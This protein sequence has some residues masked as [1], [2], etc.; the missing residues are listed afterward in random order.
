M[1]AQSRHRSDHRHEQDAKWQQVLNVYSQGKGL[2]VVQHPDN[3]PSVEK[4][5]PVGSP[6]ISQ[7]FNT[8]SGRF[9]P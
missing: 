3:Y 2:V 8:V 9:N 7:P 6:R 5:E 4:Q 1:Q